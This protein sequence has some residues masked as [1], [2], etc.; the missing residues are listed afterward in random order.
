M[1]KQVVLIQP[2]GAARTELLTFYTH[3]LLARVEF[4]L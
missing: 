1:P 3:F 4:C 2:M